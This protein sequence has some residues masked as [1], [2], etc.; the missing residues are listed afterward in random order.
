MNITVFID[1]NDLWCMAKESLS[2]VRAGTNYGAGAY[3]VVILKS[4]ISGS[5]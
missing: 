3:P 5:V 2:S 1:N 4:V